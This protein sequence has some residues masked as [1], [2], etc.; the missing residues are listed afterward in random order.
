M[1]TSFTVVTTRNCPCS[2]CKNR[3]KLTYVLIRSMNT[4]TSYPVFPIYMQCKQNTLILREKENFG[5]YEDEKSTLE[6]QDVE[7][8]HRN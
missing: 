2:G 5:P 3:L 1:N 8:D 7:K 4:C 6:E